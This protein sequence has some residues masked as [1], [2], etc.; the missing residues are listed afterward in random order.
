ML[1]RPPV[2][3]EKLETYLNFLGGF[4]VDHSPEF[5]NLLPIYE[6]LEQEIHERRLSVDKMSLIR[7]RVRQSRDQ[8]GVAISAFPSTANP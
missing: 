4:M 1:S 8:M 5:D 7:E 3:I 2:T 6:R